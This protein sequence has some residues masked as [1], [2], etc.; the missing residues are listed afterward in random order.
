M[1]REGL[2][3]IVRMQLCIML[4][5]ASNI[6]HSYAALLIYRRLGFIVL[7][8]EGAVPT[9][10]TPPTWPAAHVLF[11]YG[12]RIPGVTQMAIRAQATGNLM[13]QRD[14]LVAS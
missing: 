6:W 10:H 8:A 1:P 2:P 11:D 4:P 5:Y 9:S 13:W 3:I 12:W 7:I 14:A